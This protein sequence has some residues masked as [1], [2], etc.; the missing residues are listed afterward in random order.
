MCKI[1]LSNGGSMKNYLVKMMPTTDMID[2]L[3]CAGKCESVSEM[4]WLFKLETDVD[5]E[6][7]ERIPGVISVREEGFFKTV[8]YDEMLEQ[9]SR[10]YDL[11]EERIKRLRDEADVLAKKT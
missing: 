4:F 3:K 10:I 11:S 9:I 1:E 5:I 2:K 6:Q 8:K 7:I